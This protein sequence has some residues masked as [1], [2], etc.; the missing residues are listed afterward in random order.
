LAAQVRIPPE[1]A[2]DPAEVRIRPER[3]AD[4][5]EVLSLHRLAFGG[6]GE[7]VAGL[8]SDLRRLVG[9][10]AGLSL[11]AER[12]DQDAGELVGHAMFTPALLDAPRQL[13][14]VE[15]LSP[16]AVLPQWQGRGVGGALVRHGIEILAARSVPVVFLEG[17]PGYYSR[18]GFVSGDPLGYRRPSLRIPPAGFQVLRLPAYQAWMTGTLVYPEV[19]WNHDLVGLRPGDAISADGFEE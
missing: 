1:Q 8:V 2:A 6:H 12:A 16:L 10:D 9:A 5:A 15:V 14:T 3:A 4:H 18:F 13:V 19:F 7:R 17:D 11:V